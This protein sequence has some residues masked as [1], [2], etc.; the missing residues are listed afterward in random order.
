MFDETTIR[1]VALENVSYS[2][3]YSPTRITQINYLRPRKCF[4]RFHPSPR[5]TRASVG[6]GGAGKAKTEQGHGQ[7]KNGHRGDEATY[8]RIHDYPPLVPKGA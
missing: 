3:R 6:R 8:T 7:G 1:N 4:P 2:S 5:G